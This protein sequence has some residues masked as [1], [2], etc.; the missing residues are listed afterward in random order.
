MFERLFKNHVLANLSFVL[1]LVIGLMAYSQMP[2][3]QDPAVN[4]NWI[5]I[6]TLM[7]GASASDIEARVTDVLEEAIEKVQDVK[8]VSSNSREGLSH[9]LV[10]FE[11]GIDERTFDKRL[12]DLRRELQNKLDDLPDD[13]YDPII[14]EVTSANSFPTATLVITGP[15]DDE[16]LRVQAKN[17][18]KSIE[19]LQGVDQVIAAALHEPELQINFIPERLQALGISPAELGDTVNQ[20]YRDIA[21][22]AAQVDDLSWLVRIKGT[23]AD[24]HHLAQLPILTAHGEVPLG[25]VAEVVRARKKATKR[26]SFNGQPAVMLT[27][28]K[29]AGANTLELVE[30][31]NTYIQ[32]RNRYS[33]GTGVRLTLID[34][35]TEITRNALSIMQN[36]A[37]LGLLLVLVVTWAF[38]GVRIAVLTSIGIPFI[39]AGTFWILYGMGQTLNIMVLLGVVISLGMLVDDAVVVVEGIY[40][41]IQRGMAVYEAT[42]EALKEVI[43]PVTSAVLT[44]IA[45][46][47]PLMLLP[48]I[49]GQFMSVVPITVT[50]ALSLSLVEAYWMLPVHMTAMRI[51][52]DRPSR[53]HALRVKWLHLIRVRYTR[54]L[55]RAL[56]HPVKI[57]VGIG[58]LFLF[59]LTSLIGGSIKPELQDNPLTKPFFVQADFFASDPV[60]LFYISVEMPMG[61]PLDS[62]LEKVLEIE[63]KVRVHVRD[64]EARAITSY[65]GQ[66]FTETAFTQGEHVGQVLVALNPK[67]KALRTVAEMIDAM[68]ADVFNTVGPNKIYFV[69]LAG[70]PPAAKPVSV[71][72]RGDDVSIIRQ[73]AAELKAY[74]ETMAQ[75]EDVS[76]DDDPGQLELVLK[77]NHDAARRAGIQ[78]LQIARSLRLLIDGEIVASMQDKG[79]KLEIRVRAIPPELQSIDALLDNTL[80]AADGHAV[81]LSELVHATRQ[82]GL[83]NIRHYN[84]RRTI[85]V[86]SD[87]NKALTNTVAANQLIIDKWKEIGQRYPSIDLDFTGALD[88]IQ[89]TMDSIAILFLIGLGLMYLILGTQFKSYFQ[90]LMILSTVPMA[91]TGVVIG[92]LLTDNPLSLYTFYGLVALAGIAVNAAIV[93]I[94]A[95]NQRRDAGMSVL[96]ATLYASRRRVIPIL[97]T[98]MTTVAGLFSLAT[99]LGGHSLIWGPVATA[100]MWG[101]VVSTA[102]TLFVIP[103]LYR[104]FMSGGTSRKKTV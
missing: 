71:K 14:F 81:P 60:R 83:G 41:R 67:T 74:L 82:R 3:E 63:K 43:A 64:G 98:S 29:K 55:V 59:S 51:S 58:I 8:F 62:T 84:F 52:F 65:A 13:A 49:L 6:T 92:L 56:R 61:T 53:V 95:A 35:Q 100:I 102:L 57:L 31:I 40:F 17:V 27:V 48:G 86:Q 37:L 16:N 68:R 72:V 5:D 69:K 38:L 22:G 75:F 103:L 97:I 24:P 91:L 47:L 28:T 70:G 77:I 25:S 78:P 39:L 15:A 33:S 21:A 76:D 7:P 34:D 4:F 11:D 10:R 80:P 44:T 18:K 26:V 2:R 89:N 99:G 66:M 54:L 104:M 19:R 73:A 9:M 23:N 12:T 85:T 96:H 94:S 36:N 32:E 45:A 50:V 93:L 87:I 30:R 79:D 42:V 20:F 1:V 88:D 101:L 90:P 46:F